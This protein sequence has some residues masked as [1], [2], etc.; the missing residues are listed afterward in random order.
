MTEPSDVQA[1]RLEARKTD[2]KT[3]P[4][5]SKLECDSLCGYQA[6]AITLHELSE[7]ISRLRQAGSAPLQILETLQALES[8]MA[9]VSTLLKS[10]VYSVLLENEQ[11]IEE[12]DNPMEEDI[13]STFS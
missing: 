3:V 6:L 9:L 2:Y 4:G 10:S 11:R 5:L 7:N 1:K 12:I 13:D 8:K